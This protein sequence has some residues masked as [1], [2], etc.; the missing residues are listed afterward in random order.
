MRYIVEPSY[1]AGDSKVMDAVTNKPVFQGS[2]RACSQAAEALNEGTAL[3][4]E[5]WLS[6][7][8]ALIIPRVR[9]CPLPWAITPTPY[10]ADVTSQDGKVIA[11]CQDGD[12]ALQLCQLAHELEDELSQHD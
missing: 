10:G 4:A 3:D 2:P 5:K 9:D 12:Q 8:K 11:S 6:M 7:T 1:R